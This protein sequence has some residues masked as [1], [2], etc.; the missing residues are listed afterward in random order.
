MR[1]QFIHHRPVFGILITLFLG[2]TLLLALLFLWNMRQM[3]KETIRLAENNARMFWEKDM[4]YR[5][6]SVSHG[7]VYVPISEHTPPNPYLD[8]KDRDV[9]IAGREYTLM[10]PAYMFRQVY[11]MG[12]KRTAIQGHLTSLEPKGPQNK[13]SPWEEKAL[14]FLAVGNKEYIELVEVKGESFV[15]FMRPIKTEKSCLHCHHNRG[16]KIGLIVGGISIIVP[17]EEHLLQYKNNIKNLWLA[18][19]FIWLA[20][21]AII[22]IL[23]S[24][25]QQTILT[26]AHSERKAMELRKAKES[27]ESATLAKSIFLANMSHEIRTPMNAIIGMSTLALETGLN[28]EQHNLISKVNIASRSLLGIINDILDFSKI[29]ADKMK[30]EMVVFRLQEVFEHLSNLIGIRAEEKGLKLNITSDPDVP[31]IIQG[32][33][34]RL[35]Q[36][37]VNL[38]NNAVKFTPT[39]SI[40]IRVKLLE[41]RGEKLTLHFSV[42]DTGIGMTAEQLNII[43]HSFS[44]ADNTSTRKYGGTGL[45]LVISQKLVKMMGSKILV[46][47]ELGQ[48]STFH[49]ILHLKKGD[50]KQLPLEETEKEQAKNI[51]KVSLL[52]GKKILLV[53]DNAFNL[54]LATI[55]LKRKKLIVIHAKNG[56]E[57]LIFLRSNRVDGVLMDIQMPV[58]DG[59]TACREIRKQPN[60]KNLPVI[61]MTANVM[62]SDIKKSMASGMNDHIGKPLNVDV[63]FST[64]VKWLVKDKI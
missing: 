44:Q 37:L 22:C 4:L 10:N 3:K 57:A 36:V 25:I 7:G 33:P 1:I 18:F 50:K 43:F 27:A 55:L 13:P 6:W 46:E 16:N 52:E 56:Q 24:I 59:Y 48:G 40:I 53:E 21:I 42:S 29:E 38:G 64:L 47:S 41:E 28:Q 39:G 12:K 49:F 14:R 32:D 19:A 31:K 23:D 30:L 62:T 5:T 20:G 61:A 15:R 26:L 51:E 17:L 9:I 8:I 11:E 58:M 63:V 2:W 35:G 34:L 54:E 60:L 45:G